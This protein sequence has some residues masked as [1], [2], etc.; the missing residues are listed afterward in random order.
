[1]VLF[2]P[3][4][5]EL[6]RGSVRQCVPASLGVPWLRFN[7]R[8]EPTA[9]LQ[10]NRLN[11]RNTRSMFTTSGEF[12]I[13]LEE[14]MAHTQSSEGKNRKITACNWLPLGTLGYGD[15]LCSK[16]SPDTA[17]FAAPFGIVGNYWPLR[18]QESSL[19]LSI[20]SS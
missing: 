17:S 4:V 5:L 19:R 18:S 2:A 16:S 12:P 11:L 6:P 7:A 10:M 8:E 1:M 13:I 9:S 14:S 20:Q 3:S 15:R